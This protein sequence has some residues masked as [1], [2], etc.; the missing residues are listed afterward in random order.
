MVAVFAASWKEVCAS[1]LEQRGGAAYRP[2]SAVMLKEGAQK[3]VAMQVLDG[4]KRHKD[5]ARRIERRC[6]QTIILQRTNV[7]RP[8][9]QRAYVDTDAPP[10]G[11][12]LSC[13]C[14]MS[15]DIVRWVRS[16]VL[17]GSAVGSL[18]NQ[19]RKGSIGRSVD[20]R[21][22]GDGSAHDATQR[23]LTRVAITLSQPGMFTQH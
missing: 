15:G 2:P 16:V 9:W 23:D 11:S 4:K 18:V 10:A 21:H 14:G 12:N 19:N 13:W 3:L 20:G 6:A 8:H 5:R 22:T 7:R 1:L 17:W